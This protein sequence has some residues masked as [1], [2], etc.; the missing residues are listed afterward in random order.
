MRPTN[1]WR[2]DALG[3]AVLAMNPRNPLDLEQLRAGI[4]QRRDEGLYES[5]GL[6]GDG[7]GQA[8]FSYMIIVEIACVWPSVITPNWVR[9]LCTVYSIRSSHWMRVIDD[10]SND[11]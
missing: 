4:D 10:L 6:E 2:H 5:E 9:K 7:K 3:S 11:I 8:R 1:H